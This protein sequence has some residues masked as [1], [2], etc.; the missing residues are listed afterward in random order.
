MKLTLALALSGACALTTPAGVSASFS[1]STAATAGDVMPDLIRR[2][3]RDQAYLSRFYRVAW[4]E[5]RFDRLSQLLAE[6]TTRLDAMD[7]AALSRADQI[8]WLLL[9]HHV[10]W[11]K[12]DLE[13]DRRRLAEMAPF[14][15]FRTPL[16]NLELARRRMD[17][18]DPRA[19]AQTLADAAD[20]IKKITE[21]IKSGKKPEAERPAD[22]VVVTPVVAQRGANALDGLARMI[23][24]WAEFYDGFEPDFSWWTRRPREDAQRELRDLAKYLREEVAGLKGKDED[25]LIG[26]PI[27]RE[28]LLADMRMEML[29]YTPEQLIELGERELAWCEAELKKASAEMGLADDWKA[30]LARVKD[31]H[32]GPG[33][34]AAF[35]RDES[36]AAIAFLKERDLL[37]IPPLCEEAW[38]LEMHSPETQ[39]TLP[40][41]VYG[42]QYM[43]VGYAQEMMRHSEKLMSMRGNNRHF[44]HIVTPHELI[45]GH[46]LQGFYADRERAYRETF[47]T[48]FLIEGWALYW[49]FRFW[50]LGWAGA[51]G[52][53][54]V[55]DRIGMLFWRCHR[56]ARIIVSL[57]FHI[58]TMS[59][60]EMIDFLVD[61]VGHERSAATAEVRRYIGGQYSPLY[62]CGYMIG[63]LQMRQLHRDLVESRKMTDKAFNDAVLMEN[64]I[65]I[66]MIRAALTDVPLS[67]DWTPSWRFGEST[68]P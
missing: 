33:E 42:G 58:G 45:P 66:E 13:L 20:E 15:T 60:Q 27:G 56:A 24:D 63:G 39:R 6:W 28:A 41:A 59:P 52:Q 32:V 57:K 7:F 17:A 16:Q 21:R 2:F 36:R 61:R 38:R 4:S 62:Q 14:L 48:P 22:A 55:K 19:A 54:P 26:D 51:T 12:S 9:K 65:P 3:E 53:D 50:E 11:R 5:A 43:G 68:K 47:S 64:S 10:D 30:A 40:Y 67:K 31:E 8:D 34:Q 23:D 49:E 1:T 44:T 37:T 35:V 25:P 46:H 18:C 29:A